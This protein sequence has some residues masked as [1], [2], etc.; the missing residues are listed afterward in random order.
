MPWYVYDPKDKDYLCEEEFKRGKELWQADP[1]NASTYATY[2]KAAE[3]FADID[4]E[5]ILPHIRPVWI[6][7]PLVQGPPRKKWE[8]MTFTEKMAQIEEDFENKLAGEMQGTLTRDLDPFRKE[9]DFGFGTGVW[10][11]PS[12][13]IDVDYA[14]LEMRVLAGMT[15]EERTDYEKEGRADER[16][17]SQQRGRPSSAGG[18]PSSGLPDIQSFSPTGRIR[19]RR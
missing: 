3:A 16:N 7:D 1:R 10:Q 5:E 12:Q 11:N 9:G 14:G 6:E 8:E 4:I 18:H 19:R 13:K 15:S 17:K 2:E